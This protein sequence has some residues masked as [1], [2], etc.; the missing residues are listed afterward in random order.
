MK[1]EL[2]KGR[3]G[4]VYGTTLSGRLINGAKATITDIHDNDALLIVKLD[5]EDNHIEIGKDE[6]VPFKIKPPSGEAQKLIDEL[7]A[8]PP[9]WQS[10]PP[11]PPTQKPIEPPP[12]TATVQK[13]NQAPIDWGYLGIFIYMSA[14]LI[15]L[16]LIVFISTR[17]QKQAP[18][19]T[20]TAFILPPNTG[21][22]TTSPSSR[23]YTPEGRKM[24]SETEVMSE[25]EILGHSKII[26]EENFAWGT[27]TK[28]A[29][30]ICIIEDVK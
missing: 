28:R 16:G 11:N 17:A 15:G 25:C 30:L 22:L 13:S 29:K 23:I 19:K 21:P 14:I 3:R 20:D 12:V 27:V 10:P 6:F 1:P 7:K 26:L 8:K 18:L 9:Y 4:R 24:F 5:G 2:K